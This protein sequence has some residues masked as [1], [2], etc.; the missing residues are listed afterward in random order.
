MTAS[1]AIG[2][3]VPVRVQVQ[4][5]EILKMGAREWQGRKLG[6]QERHLTGLRLEQQ[7]ILRLR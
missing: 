5:D 7:G 2:V 4:T 6:Q 3:D 1:G